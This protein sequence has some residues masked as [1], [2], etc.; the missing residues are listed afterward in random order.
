VNAIRRLIKRSK[1]DEKY[2]SKMAGANARNY[3]PVQEQQQ[4]V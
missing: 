4:Q 3:L 2:I 1:D